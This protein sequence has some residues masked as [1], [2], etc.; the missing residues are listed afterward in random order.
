MKILIVEDDF[1]SRRILKEILA[2]FGNCDVVVDG[3][4]A[5]Q[6]FQ[7]AHEEKAP[8]DLICLDIMMPN[9][10]GHE[11]LS[12]IRE[13]EK[14][15]SISG[16]SEVKVIMVTALDDPK[17]V[18]KAYYRGGATSYIVKPIEKEKLVE[19]LRVLGLIR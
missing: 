5:I 7:L 4:E 11:A 16:A 9:M 12:R 15:R 2:E 6:A 1:I 19:E 3:E 18:F 10:D 8:Y 13:F 17:T 14:E